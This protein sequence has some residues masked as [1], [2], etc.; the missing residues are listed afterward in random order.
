MRG[1]VVRGRVGHQLQNGE[2][3]MLPSQKQMFLLFSSQDVSARVC[4]PSSGD[5]EEDITGDEVRKL[6]CWYGICRPILSVSY[7]T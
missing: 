2:R 1:G 7:P 6:L 5:L 3:K 4:M